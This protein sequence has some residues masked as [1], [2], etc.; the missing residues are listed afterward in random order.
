MYL[1]SLINLSDLHSRATHI[2]VAL[3]F[4]QRRGKRGN[5]NVFVLSCC[6]VFPA[7]RLL[8]CQR[9]EVILFMIVDSWT[10]K[11]LQLYTCLIVLNSICF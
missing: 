11:C 6:V 8:I 5:Q 3:D 4:W 9:T 2:V 10:M 7:N 1:G